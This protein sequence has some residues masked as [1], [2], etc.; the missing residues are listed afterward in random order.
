MNG[1]HTPAQHVAILRPE[2]LAK[3][4]DGTK[5]VECRLTR[6][7]SAPFGRV[8]VGEWIWLKQSGGPVRAVA[9][10]ADVLCFEGVD[11]PRLAAIRTAYGSAV[12]AP[13][14]FWVHK[15]GLLQCTL[16]RLAG[17]R[18]VDPFPLPK[19]DL[20]AWVVLP[21]DGDGAAVPP[22]DQ[23]LLRRLLARRRLLGTSPADAPGCPCGD[24]SP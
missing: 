2:Y 14:S 9:C 19:H 15:G 18:R 13:G 5:T 7:K 17:V 8:R 3:V 4:L 11:P 16:I 24:G 21:D 6:I 12:G 10:A 22:H 20:R 23:P 1:S